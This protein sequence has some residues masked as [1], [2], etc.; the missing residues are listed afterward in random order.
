M[1]M[2]V[3]ITCPTPAPRYLVI[4]VPYGIIGMRIWI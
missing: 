4:D 3:E 2:R 1:R